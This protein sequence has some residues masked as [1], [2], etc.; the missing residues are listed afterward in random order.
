MKA[1]ILKMDGRLITV[2]RNKV[3]TA[4]G[5]SVYITKPF[6]CEVQIHSYSWFRG[7]KTYL[8]WQ[9]LSD[10]QLLCFTLWERRKPEETVTLPQRS[11]SQRRTSAS[12]RR[13]AAASYSTLISVLSFGSCRFGKRSVSRAGS[14][15]GLRCWCARRS[16]QIITGTSESDAES[17]RLWLPC[18]QRSLQHCPLRTDGIIIGTSKK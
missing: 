16:R 17:E 1:F 12:Y 2:F 9:G 3:V 4:F 7:K 5:S 13:R 10:C 6:I 18:T 14:P 8:W 11:D 15:V